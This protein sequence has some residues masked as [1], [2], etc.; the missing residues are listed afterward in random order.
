MHT[1][2]AFDKFPFAAAGARGTFG[3]TGGQMSERS[4]FLSASQTSASR[5]EP[6]GGGQGVGVPFFCLLFLGKQKE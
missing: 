6:A 5:R 3:E 4:E 2:K 1:I